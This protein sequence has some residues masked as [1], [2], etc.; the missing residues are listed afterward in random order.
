MYIYTLKK[1]GAEMLAAAFLPHGAR[2]ASPM[3][4]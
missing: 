3:E 2:W 4:P 1:D